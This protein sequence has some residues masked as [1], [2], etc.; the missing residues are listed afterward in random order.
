M[1]EQGSALP[2]EPLV[3]LFSAAN[4]WLYRVSNGRLG[5]TMKGAPVLLL[6]VAGRRSGKKRTLPVVYITTERGHALIASKGGAPRHPAWYLN[7]EAAKRAEIQIGTHR[8]RVRVEIVDPASPLYAELWQ[9]GLA[10][11]PNYAAYKARTAR[12]IP[13]VELLPEA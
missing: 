8:S 2:P 3:R 7:L 6:T 4:V 13:I 10:L 5:A 11:Y 12:V 9:K 1:T